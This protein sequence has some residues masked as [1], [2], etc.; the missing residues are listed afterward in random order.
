MSQSV[1]QR[2]REI[3]VRVALGASPADALRLIFN[4]GFR[5]AVTGVAIG[6][7]LAFVVARFGKAL[8]FDVT[9][10]DPLVYTAAP[11]VLLAFAALGCWVPARRAATVDPLVTLR[12]S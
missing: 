1:A 8:L 11:L 6:V 9:P 4:E 3:G 10:S 5:M 7:A 2:R 12:D